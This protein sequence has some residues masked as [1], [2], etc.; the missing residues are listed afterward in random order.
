MVATRDLKSRGDFR[1]GSS[2]AART[3]IYMIL[4]VDNLLPKIIDSKQYSTENAS[5][6]YDIY[7][8][9]IL[10]NLWNIAKLHYDLTNVVVVEKW[11]H[12]ERSISSVKWHVDE[13]VKYKMS[14]GITRLPQC[15][16]LYY[17]FVA[18]D[19]LGGWF[20]THS[21]KIRPITNRAIIFDSDIQ[22]TVE[23]CRGT[24]VSMIYNPWNHEIET[25]NGPIA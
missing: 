23:P 15:T 21:E 20:C 24:R 16:M 25:Y 4:V 10:I 6:I 7:K 3:R 13:D 9:P 19:L 5:L 12:T 2:P 17:P 11:I 1:A 14:T 18:E 8:D 22:H